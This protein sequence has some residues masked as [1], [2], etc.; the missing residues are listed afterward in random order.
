MR[1]ILRTA[2]PGV[3]CIGFGTRSGGGCCRRRFG[4]FRFHGGCSGG[5]FGSRTFSAG[6]GFGRFDTRRRRVGALAAG[7]GGATGFAIAPGS[8]VRNT[9]ATRGGIRGAATPS[10]CVPILIRGRFGCAGRG[11][12]S[13]GA[14]EA[15]GA[16]G[17][18]AGEV[19]VAA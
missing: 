16:A 4:G 3:S 5:C 2:L 15:A 11:D 7:G 10:R 13:A 19:W 12:G 6:C 1:S 17:A 14:G 18:G 8:G 9:V